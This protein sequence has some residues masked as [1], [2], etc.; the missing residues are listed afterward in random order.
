[1]RKFAWVA[2]GLAVLATGSVISGARVADAQSAPAAKSQLDKILEKKEL[3]V[4]MTLQFKPEMYKDAAGKPAG[5]DVEV[6][7]LLA[8]DLGVSIPTVSR[9]VEA[10]RETERKKVGAELKALLPSILDRAFAGE[11]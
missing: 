3:R 4:G 7:N 2:A 8:K 11:L 1:M 10:L 5:Y 6:L 9:C